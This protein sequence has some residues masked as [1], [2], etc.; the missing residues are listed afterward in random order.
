[1]GQI[2]NSDSIALSGAGGGGQGSVKSVDDITPDDSGNVQL[3]AYTPDN[4]PPATVFDAGEVN[5]VPH[6]T[7]AAVT[8]DEGADGVQTVNF[9][10]PAGKP[11]PVNTLTVGEVTTV[12]PGSGSSATI[13]GDAPNQVLNLE[14]EQGAPGEVPEG[15]MTYKGT[16][17]SGTTYVENDLVTATVNNITGDYVC[18]VE[19]TTASLTD[20]SAWR[21]IAGMASA[22]D[23][24]PASSDGNIAYNRSV[25]VST[26]TITPQCNGEQNWILNI[27][28]SA[29]VDLS[30]FTNPLFNTNPASALQLY[31]DTKDAPDAITVT[32]TNSDNYWLPDGSYSADAPVF[33]LDDTQPM[34]RI[35]VTN[36]TVSGA[37]GVM[38]R[39]VYPAAATGG[40]IV[41]PELGE[42]GSTGLFM[43]INDSTAHYPGETF[44]ASTLYYAG[45]N[46]G[47]NLIQSSGIHPDGGT[48]ELRGYFQVST[49]ASHSASELIRIDGT[50]LMQST[51]LLRATTAS[52]HIRNCRYSTPDN[53]MIDCEVLV[54]GKWYP[55]T[56]SPADSTKWG[57]AIYSA[58]A[59]G[60]FGE[61]APYQ[62]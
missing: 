23:G 57:P 60:R 45:I 33:I 25:D 15:S 5:T 30:T 49:T 41:I 1:M 50:S 7:P 47:G 8:F 42:P 58:A 32:F 39:Q 28:A 52:D 40:G 34:T 27:S 3:D 2:Y 35:E 43:Y 18:I 38:V 24:V 12:P 9:D 16:W 44:A 51:H 54:N 55:F 46:D 29:T 31:I 6:D 11:G 10:I 61:V 26:A 17:T 56:A 36:V 48:W 14:L 22:L 13:T 20:T 4:P 37:P 62:A 53:A 59:A 21:R 19:S